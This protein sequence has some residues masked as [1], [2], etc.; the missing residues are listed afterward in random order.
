M[1][2]VS[3][4]DIREAFIV[5]ETESKTGVSGMDENSP[6]FLSSKATIS[7]PDFLGESGLISE[8]PNVA[9]HSGFLTRHLVS[10]LRRTLTTVDI[11]GQDI[12]VNFKDRGRLGR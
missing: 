5:L 2:K 3:L 11:G 12:P 7:L 9:A 4:N 10:S 6:V 1:R 8:T